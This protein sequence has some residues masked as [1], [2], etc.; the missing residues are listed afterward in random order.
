MPLVRHE[1]QAALLQAA[2][3]SGQSDRPAHPLLEPEQRVWTRVRRAETQIRAL[4]NRATVDI[5]PPPGPNRRDSF[6]ACTLPAS[7]S[8]ARQ[9]A[10]VAAQGRS[11]K[12]VMLR[13]YMAML[14]VSQK[15]FDLLKVRG[16]E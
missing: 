10:G 1:V 5:F 3:E 2:A 14:G 11:P 16:Q 4:F 12:V 13:V 15:Y 8:P 7:E 6:F 9:Y